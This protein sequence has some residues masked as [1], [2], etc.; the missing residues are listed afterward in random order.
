MLIPQEL[1]KPVDVLALASFLDTQ[2]QHDRIGPELQV[3][4]AHVI[5]CLGQ[6]NEHVLAGI[7]DVDAVKNTVMPW[8]ILLHRHVKT[9]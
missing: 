8:T 5:Q 1:G 9:S 7:R 4:P 2:F 6:H 3:C